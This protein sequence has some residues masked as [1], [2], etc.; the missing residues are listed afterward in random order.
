MQFAFMFVVPAAAAKGQTAHFAARRT[1]RRAIGFCINFNIMRHIKLL[2][3]LT[4][5]AHEN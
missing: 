5:V 4:Y 1:I 2:A 3:I